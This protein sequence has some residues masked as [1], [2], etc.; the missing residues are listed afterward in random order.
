MK[1]D[2]KGYSHTIGHCASEG[3]PS[4]SGKQEDAFRSASSKP[5]ASSVKAD[6]GMGQYKQLR[7][8]K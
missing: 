5:K 7:G 6:K 3:K 1:K 4:Q 8:K 2:G